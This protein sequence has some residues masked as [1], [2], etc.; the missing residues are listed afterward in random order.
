[1][2]VLRVLGASD[3]DFYPLS[4]RVVTLGSAP[5]NDVSLNTSGVADHHA[6]IQL[7]GAGFVLR[8]TSRKLS[9]MVNGKKRREHT[10]CHGDKLTIGEAQLEFS[11]LDPGQPATKRSTDGPEL[12]HLRALATRL[13]GTYDVEQVLEDV[14]DAVLELSDGQKG[15]VILVR[16]GRWSVPVARSVDARAMEDAHLHLSDSIIAHA[17]ASRQ[18]LIIADVRE[19]E[20]F[21]GAQSVVDLELS[22]VLCL[23]LFAHGELLGLIYVGDDRITGYFAGV[24]LELLQVFASMASLIVA[25]ALHVNALEHD[26][27]ALRGR[28]QS[29]RFGEV[30][31]ASKAMQTIFQAVKRVAPASVSVLITGETGTGKELIAHE[32]HRRSPRADGPFITINCGA[33]PEHL[34]ESE[35]FGHERGAF[36]GATSRRDGKFHAAHRGTLFLDEIGEMPGALQVK[37]LRVLQ[38]HCVTRVGSNT[39]E[40]LDFR[41]LAATHVD[42]TEAVASKRFREDLYYRLNV[43]QLHLPP[44]RKRGEDVVL[45]ANFLIERLAPE[46][47]V[48]PRPLHTRAREAICRYDWPGNVRQLENRIKRALILA[49]GPAL[50]PT[51]LEL[52]ESALPPRQSLAEAKE[53]FALTYILETLERNGGNR[54]QTARDLDVDPRTIFRYLE[55]V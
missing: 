42:L 21:E 39:P 53:R 23:P 44:L 10:L 2:A 26:R 43:V 5:A 35:L 54:S 29:Q 4:E 24:D 33:I 14:L 36:T 55:K 3:P 48:A 18:P 52:E 45:L 30:I 8:T 40:A 32:I 37:L 19:E 11:L 47:G 13:T 1:M 46:L 6:T 12:E 20:A 22:S 15:F 41:V 49:T 17:I 31:G 50:T 25:N 7:D 28:L 51:D 27:D 9:V 34:L 16:E 38:E